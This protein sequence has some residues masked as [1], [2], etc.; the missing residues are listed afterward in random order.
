[1]FAGGILSWLVIIP[2]IVFF[3]ADLVMYPGTEP[4]SEIFA[5][6]GA[7]RDLGHLYPVYRRR[8]LGGRP[9]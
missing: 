5:K 7:R 3:G 6:G 2:L 4:I 1:M 8:R 9:V